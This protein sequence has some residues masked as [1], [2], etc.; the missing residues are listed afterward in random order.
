LLIEKAKK[1][2]TMSIHSISKELNIK[3]IKNRENGVL[4]RIIPKEFIE[5]NIENFIVARINRD[6]V[7]F[8]WFSTE[9]PKDML[10]YTE[11]KENID[12]CIYSEQIGVK[13]EFQGQHIGKELY[14]F[15]KNNYNDKGILVFVNTAP[16]KN[17]ASLS[18]HDS[19]GFK[20]VGE[21]YREDFC[22]FKDYKANLLKL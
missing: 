4:L 17:I 3:Y 1:E 22:G 21:F 19:L 6:V 5:D 10:E 9:Y 14:R 8:L 11:L 15:L 2:D 7:G 13:R 16:E 12:G 20:T 18:F